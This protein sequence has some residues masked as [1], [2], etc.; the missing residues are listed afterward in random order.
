MAREPHIIIKI[1]AILPIRLIKIEKNNKGYS[2]LLSMN[3]WIAVL[4][5]NT[6]NLDITAKI[7]NILFLNVI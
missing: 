7:K 2:S 5:T 4:K 3:I 6:P 1:N